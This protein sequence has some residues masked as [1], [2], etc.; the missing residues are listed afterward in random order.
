M[1]LLILVHHRFDLWNV[2][3]WFTEKL[4]AEFRDVEVVCLNTYEGA[5]E[6]LRNVQTV[7]TISLRPE[8]LALARQLQWVHAPTAAVHQLLF[9]EL[10]NS[11]VILTNSTDVHVPVVAE[12]VIAA[13]LAVANKVPTAVLF[14][15][16]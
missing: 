14:P 16:Y 2:P 15:Q 12:H 7:F 10:V 1:K 11:N 6:H 4:A 13:I 3:S 8:Q 5:E 9:A